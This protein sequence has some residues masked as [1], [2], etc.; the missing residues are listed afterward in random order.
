MHDHP[1]LLPHEARQ[2]IDERIRTA[3]ATRTAR[4]AKGSIRGRRR[5]RLD[6][7]LGPVSDRLD[8]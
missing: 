3:A 8:V 2:L 1:S 5:H 4:A 6:R 7:Q